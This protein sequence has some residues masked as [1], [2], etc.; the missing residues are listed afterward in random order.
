METDTLAHWIHGNLVNLAAGTASERANKY[1]P[2][3]EL[4]AKM[5]REGV[6]LKQGTPGFNVDVEAKL[7]ELG[8]LTVGATSKGQ[9]GSLAPPRR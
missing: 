9:V 2:F 3:P 6:R 5:D 1:L 4:K 8:F 7:K